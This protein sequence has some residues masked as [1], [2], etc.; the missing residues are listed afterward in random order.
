MELRKAEINFAFWIITR[1]IYTDDFNTFLIYDSCLY[2]CGA[3]L[4]N[5]HNVRLKLWM[6]TCI[7]K[8]TFS[9]IHA[10]TTLI[11]FGAFHTNL[12]KIATI[13]LIND[14]IPHYVATANSTGT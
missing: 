11:L 7:V 10:N 14:S 6:D 8:L 13:I 5:F 12:M 9:G 2:S 4:Y 3:L 1:T